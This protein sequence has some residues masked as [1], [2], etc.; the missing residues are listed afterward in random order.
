MTPWGTTIERERRN[1][2][3]VSV[4]AYAYEIKNTSIMSDGDYDALCLE[5]SPMRTTGHATLDAFF[6]K[7]FDPSTGMWV[8]QHPEIPGLARIYDKH[9]RT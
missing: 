1:R 2:I 4:A 7:H 9:W 5:V 3:L 8:H 6:R